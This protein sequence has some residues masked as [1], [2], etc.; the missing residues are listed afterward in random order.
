MYNKAWTI[1]EEEL[2]QEMAGLVSFNHIAN[3]VGRTPRAV[4]QKLKRLGITSTIDSGGWINA[5]SL[6]RAIG[7]DGATVIRWIEQHK[8]PLSNATLRYRKKMNSVKQD[9]Y[10]ITAEQFWNWAKKHKDLINFAKIDEEALFPLPDWFEEEKKKD[11]AIPK[12]HQVH[13]TPEEDQKIWDYYYNR[14]MS[15]EEI[16]PLMHRSARSISSRMQV[17]RKRKLTLTVR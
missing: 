2:I 5:K 14:Q 3:K 8:L 13:Y 12:K 17:I 6:A 9:S 10:H 7:V 11:Y 1:E 15:Y 16:A 4:E